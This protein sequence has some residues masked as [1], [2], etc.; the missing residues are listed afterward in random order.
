MAVLQ[1]AGQGG[2]PTVLAG[3]GGRFSIRF[4]S[5]P[6]CYTGAKTITLVLTFLGL[7][8]FAVAAGWV[9]MDFA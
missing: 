6:G 8:N 9:G 5:Q 4:L 7:D 2:V 3:V 1:E